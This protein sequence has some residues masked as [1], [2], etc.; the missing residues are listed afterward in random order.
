[1]LEKDPEQRYNINQVDEA[2]IRIQ[3]KS[4]FE[5]PVYEI[6]NSMKKYKSRL[7]F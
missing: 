7:S 5:P 2:I 6:K 1:M 3:L 4:D